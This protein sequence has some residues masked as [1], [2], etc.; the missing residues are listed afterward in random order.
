M[1]VHEL[2]RTLYDARDPGAAAAQAVV[3]FVI[4]AVLSFVQFRFL[5]QVVYLL[6]QRRV[7][8]L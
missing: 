8:Q 5:D 2:Y 7:L 4:I 6:V 3:L 1:L